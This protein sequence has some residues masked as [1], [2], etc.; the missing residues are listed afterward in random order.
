MKNG[1]NFF[2][3]SKN[4]NDNALDL[5]LNEDSDNTID[6]K[7]LDS[8][9]DF[10]TSRKDIKT[11]HNDLSTKEYFYNKKLQ[12]YKTEICRS[13]SEMG[14]C[15]YGTKC[16]FAHDYKELRNVNRHPRY[17][18]ETCR[19]FWEEGSCPYGKRCCFI[20]IKN[21]SIGNINIRSDK[22]K[23]NTPIDDINMY[24]SR[25]ISIAQDIIDDD[26]E[27]GSIDVNNYK[28]SDTQK[29]AQIDE[30]IS[31]L[32]K[33][34]ELINFDKYFDN[35]ISSSSEDTEDD[36]EIYEI[37][38]NNDKSN[39]ITFEVPEYLDC[40][41]YKIENKAEKEWNDKLIKLSEEDILFMNTL[42]VKERRPFW[43][44][45]EASKWTTDSLF[46]VNMNNHK[47]K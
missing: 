24:E 4:P 6:I 5:I 37:E 22:I 42:F 29:I 17:K 18:T 15:K 30:S 7:C 3:L 13:H 27:F 23:I 10:I 12:L 36:H 2:N 47:W 41:D 11:K 32:N 40:K 46:Y 43:E 19:T 38:I 16:Q 34:D 26:V 35:E 21:N 28:K 14:Y 45:N 31:L 1:G 25:I 8:E 9:I 33:N 44:S 39:S 20:N